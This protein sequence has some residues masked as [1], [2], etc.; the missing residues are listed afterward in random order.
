MQDPGFLG[1]RI[2]KDQFF[3]GPG[4]SGFRF[5][6]FQVVHG[7]GFSVSR[8]F[9]VQVFHGPGFSGPESRVRVQASDCAN[10]ANA[11]V[12]EDYTKFGTENTKLQNKKE[13]AE[14]TKSSERRKTNF[15][16]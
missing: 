7:L 14:N 12:C 9:R 15:T 10:V 13:S 8:F 4:F 3:Q 16:K 1:S 2:F 5:F 11:K 6:R